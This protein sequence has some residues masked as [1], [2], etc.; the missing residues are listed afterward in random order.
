MLTRGQDSP[1]TAATEI[2][3]VRVM[4]E[5]LANPASIGAASIFA[6]AENTL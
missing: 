2:D 6:A 1:E 4:A 5:A 3:F